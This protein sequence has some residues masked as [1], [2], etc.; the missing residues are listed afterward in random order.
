MSKQ[1]YVVRT[2]PNS[3]RIASSAF[4]AKGFESFMPR[5]SVPAGEDRRKRVPL[6][7]GYLF[8]RCDIEQHD[9]PVISRLPGVLGWVRFD[10]HVPPVPDDL[11]DE[12][13]GRLDVIHRSGGM[14]QRFKV[15]QLVR[16]AHGKL[17]GLATVLEEPDSPE[18]RI[19]VLFEFMGRQ[20]PTVVPWHSLSPLAGSA[21]ETRAIKRIRRTRGRGRWVAGFGPGKVAQ[22]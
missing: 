5:V 1:W 15:G 2:K 10:G 22:A 16:L 6:F 17:D 13:R 20:V 9:L 14:W 8:L 18:D 4:E 19:R 3:D 21:S 11:I 12:L 7:P